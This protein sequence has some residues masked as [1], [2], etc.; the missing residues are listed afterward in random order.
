MSS[1]SSSRST[2]A[3]TRSS[4]PAPWPTSAPTPSAAPLPR[5]LLWDV[6]ANLQSPALRGLAN[7]LLLLA[8]GFTWFIVMTQHTGPHRFIVLVLMPGL[9]LLLGT[10]AWAVL[11]AA[12]RSLPATTAPRSWWVRLRA[13]AVVACLLLPLR[14]ARAGVTFLQ[15]PGRAQRSFCRALQLLA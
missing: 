9:A 12:A 2:R 3:S 5:F 6:P 10:L 13:W 1:T 11:A 4:T 15:H 7:A 14:A 8:G